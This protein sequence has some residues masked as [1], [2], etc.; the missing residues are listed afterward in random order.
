MKS[1][2]K[3]KLVYFLILLIIVSSVVILY[4]VSPSV[5]SGDITELAIATNAGVSCKSWTSIIESD[6]AG[7]K[8]TYSPITV[9]FPVN[10]Q[11]NVLSTKTGNTLSLLDPSTNVECRPLSSAF[12]DFNLV[13]GTVRTTFYGLQDNGQWITLKTVDRNI[14]TI[15]KPV[16]NQKQINPT[17]TITGTEINSK[18]TSSKE[19]FTTQVKII[20]N[21]NFV[22]KGKSTGTLVNSGTA[23][24]SNVVYVKLYNPV[25]NPTPSTSTV[26]KL[27]SLSATSFDLKNYQSSTISLTVTGEL[28]SW[29]DTEGVPYVEIVDPNRHVLGKY[30]MNVKKLLSSSTNT[31]E[32]KAVNINIPKSPQGTWN[33]YMHSNGDI[34]K[35]SSV[36]PSTDVK[37]FNIYDTSGTSQPSPVPVPT[38]QCMK[39][40]SGQ[41]IC[42]GDDEFKSGGVCYAKSL[43][44]C[45]D[46]HNEIISNPHDIP[47]TELGT[48]SAFIAYKLTFDQGGIAKGIIPE[49]KSISVDFEPLSFVAVPNKVAEKLQTVTLINS[50]DTSLLGASNI[51]NLIVNTKFNILVDGGDATGDVQLNSAQLKRLGAYTTARDVYLMNQLVL[52]SVDI[53]NFLSGVELTDGQNITLQSTSDG[54][55]DVTN[56]SGT[57][58]GS[59]TGLIFTYDLQYTSDENINPE[60][61]EGLSGQEL[62]DCRGSDPDNCVDLVDVIGDEHCRYK[63]GSTGG[64]CQGLTPTECADQGKNGF[65]P[66]DNPI[67]D[68]FGIGCNPSGE[69]SDILECPNGS[70]ASKDTSGKSICLDNTKRTLVDPLNTIAD[71]ASG[72]DI[73]LIVIIFLA[74][75]FIVL[76]L[77]LAK[78]RRK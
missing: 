35:I 21:A 33:V 72:L 52:N 50:I 76:M 59:F 73:Q 67:C 5:F 37:T 9:N 19:F 16:L 3:K 57:H 64:Y 4:A 68:A 11:F 32:F 2:L 66:T 42:L 69:G 1:K 29:K 47:K 49:D 44:W 74:F 36:L 71:I 54:T 31:W 30:Q 12:T 41:E 39:L 13:G 48:A 58:K 6:V 14:S 15:S 61:C 18:L 56:T 25:T 65:T 20:V 53:S 62:L 34:R 78:R 26:V 10:T 70:F 27:T 40:T 24:M 63:E 77:I 45:I 46:Y 51:S 38:T 7:N 43:Q 22:F 60:A 55:F 28:P 75:L 17:G 23:V 8:I